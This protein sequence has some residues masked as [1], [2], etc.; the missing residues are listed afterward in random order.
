MGKTRLVAEA[1][2][3]AE[4]AGFEVLA[5]RGGE[6]E[7]EFAYGVMRQLFEPLLATAGA[8]LIRQA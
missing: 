2:A 3:S 8:D 5:A 6:L 4:A 7:E 1:R